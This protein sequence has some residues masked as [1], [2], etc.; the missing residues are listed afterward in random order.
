MNNLSASERLGEMIVELTMIMRLEKFFKTGG[1]M[2][3]GTHRKRIKGTLLRV[4]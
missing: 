1:S 2:S 4:P 3:L